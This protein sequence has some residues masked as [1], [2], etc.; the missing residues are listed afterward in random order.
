[1]TAKEDAVK[2]LRLRNGYMATTARIRAS[3]LHTV[4]AMWEETPQLRDADVVQLV[5]RLAPQVIAG[6]LQIANLTSAFL[7]QQASLLRGIKVDPAPVDRK[8]ILAVRAGIPI[9]ELLHRPAVAVYTSLA[10]G[11]TYE[12]ARKAGLNRLISI[13]GTQMQQTKTVQ[14]KKALEYSGA[15][16]FRRVLSG[17]ENC[18]LCVVAATQRYSVIRKA[19]IHNGCDCGIEELPAGEAPKQIIDQELLDAVNNLKDEKG[20]PLAPEDIITIEEHGELG[21]MLT[22]RRREFAK[23]PAVL[24]ESL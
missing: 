15:E 9:E 2:A 8:E 4:M 24:D 23:G 7:A 5:E 6:Q 17:S 18:K 16:Y 12:Q 20:E 1:M 14:A 13:A 11:A 22:W 10:K 3:V 21:P 19:E